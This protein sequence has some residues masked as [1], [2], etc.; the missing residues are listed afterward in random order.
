MTR[1]HS[2]S[3]TILSVSL[4]LVVGSVYYTNHLAH[5]LAQ[6]E[7]ERVQI[8][9]EA[10]ERLILADDNE[11]ID[12]Y[13]TI[14]ERNNT[15]PVY[16][17]DSTNTILYTRNV[18]HP[19]DD[20]TTLSKP[21]RIAFTDENGQPVTQF[22]YYDESMLLTQLR[23][24]PYFQFAIIFLFIVVAV[25]ALVSSLRSERNR[26]WAGLSKETAHQ[27]GTPLSALMG[28]YELLLA[29][30]PN[31]ELLPQMKTDLSRLQ[32]IAER[33]S[34]VGSEPQLQPTAIVP[35]VKRTLEYMRVRVSNKVDMSFDAVQLANRPLQAITDE[36]VQVLLN[37]PLFEWVVENL[38]KN[39]IDA[40]GG[41]GTIHV[42]LSIKDDTVIIDVSDTG[43][44]IERRA[45]RHLFQPGY[46]T[47][48]RGWGLGLSLSKRIV[49]D[50]HGGKLFVKTSELGKGT[51][52]RIELKQAK[53]S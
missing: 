49:E 9:A 19:V 18:E 29:R 10:T 50:Y 21:I 12:F 28:W 30:Y 22:I 42:A 40:M 44:G 38:I 2:L 46:S 5:A 14:I 45:L 31:D 39:A 51:T 34:K 23:Y 48:S 7:Q 8:W 37:P 33:F 41:K 1:E 6:E 26:V 47:K 20:P 32:V 13:T 17:L 11:D 35:I 24:V 16:I 52:F 36:S 27:L 53:E 15:I 25:F 43:K 3:I 4:L